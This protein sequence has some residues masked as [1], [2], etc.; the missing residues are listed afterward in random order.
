MNIV[1][2]ENISKHLAEG[3]ACFQQAFPDEQVFVFHVVNR[4]GRGIKDDDLIPAIA[5]DTGV[6]ITQDLNMYRTPHLK[7]LYRKHKIGVFFIRPPK[8][9]ASYWYLVGM[10]LK[11]W[12][13]IKKT[14]TAMTPPFAFLITPKKIGPI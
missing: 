8:N 14:A 5:R 1:F 7:L 11:K 4:Y 10:I 9:S 12:A 2:D 3:F 6:L 13:E